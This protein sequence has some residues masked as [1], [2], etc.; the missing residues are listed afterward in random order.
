M[1]LKPHL[2]HL[3]QLALLKQRGLVVSDDE[4][5]LK[6][7][8]NLG[9][10]R[11]SSYLF[12]FRETVVLTDINGK[13]RYVVAD[14]FRAG[15]NFESIQKLYKFDDELRML[16][17][18]ALNQL[19]ICIRAQTAYFLGMIDPFAH[20]NPSNL[21][22]SEANRPVSRQGSTANTMHEMWIENYQLLQKTAVK[23]EEHVKDHLAEY[24]EPL[25]IFI[26]IEFFDFGQT[27]TLF[28]MLQHSTKNSVANIYGIKNG[29]LLVSWCTSMNYY[30]NLCAHHGRLWNRT[31]TLK[32]T[33]PRPGETGNQIEHLANFP[34]AARIY[35]I[36]TILSYLMSHVCPELNWGQRV[37]TLVSQFPTETGFTAELSMGFPANWQ[38]LTIWK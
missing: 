12:P 20:L 11:L 7:L 3:D 23:N 1:Y 28:R 22:E 6:L 24:G 33:L 9:Y 15:T 37:G 10:Y 16:S 27:S 32:P 38:N 13:S 2:T 17:L 18:E 31:Y 4:E 26:A 19:E 35:P 30:R 34:A 5:A 8:R 14:D 21:I 25:P 29:S 36:L